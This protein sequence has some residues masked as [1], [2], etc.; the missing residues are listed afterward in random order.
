M[1]KIVRKVT[2]LATELDD[3]TAELESVR[4]ELGE[5]H[6]LH[7]NQRERLRQCAVKY[8]E[9]QGE[10]ADLRRQLISANATAQSSQQ[11]VARLMDQ[12]AALTKDLTRSPEVLSEAIMTG[13][14]TILN[15]YQVAATERDTKLAE[16]ISMGGLGLDNTGGTPAGH[17]FPDIEFD[18]FVEKREHWPTPGMMTSSPVTPSEGQHPVHQVANG[19]VT[20]TDGQAMFQAGTSG[21][22]PVGGVES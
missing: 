6:R 2:R 9:S 8:R 21:P 17:F 11:I 5:L 16:E 10:I 18:D 14:S 15:G 12:V 1:S 7:D 13:I 22:P 3:T 4:Y 19:Q 20:R